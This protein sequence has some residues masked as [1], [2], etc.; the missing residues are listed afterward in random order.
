MNVKTMLERP[1]GGDR[2]QLR[3]DGGPEALI[4]RVRAEYLEMPGLCLSV[5]QAC[6]LWQIEAT[7]CTR[8][9]DGLVAE[10]FLRRTATGAFIAEVPSRP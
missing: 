1:S 8:I 10:R 7:H 5:Q 2:S 4:R 9:L 6:R 3:S